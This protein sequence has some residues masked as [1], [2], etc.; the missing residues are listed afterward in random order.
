MRLI[1]LP[2]GGG[3]T[4][5]LVKIMLDD[6]SVYYVAPTRK[7]ADLAAQLA[8]QVAP[9]RNLSGSRFLSAQQVV[10]DAYL[11][12]SATIVVD[13]IDGVLEVLLSRSV[14][15]GTYTD[16]ETVEES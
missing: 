2:R 14:A 6:D 12:G 15:V 11:P 8:T 4:T 9:K 3:K 1:E 16:R 5:E 13:E 10:S 7:Q